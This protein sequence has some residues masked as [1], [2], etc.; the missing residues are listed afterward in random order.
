[1]RP[2]TEE[3]TKLVFAKLACYIGRNIQLLIDRKDEN[4]CF[5][6]LG[7]RVYYVK[8]SIVRAAN[9]IGRDDLLSVGTCFGKF[10]HNGQFR[11][12][13]TCLDYLSQYAKYKVWIKPSSENSFV[14]GNHVLKAGLGRITDNTP[15]NQGV[16]VYTMGDIP[17]G[18]GT[19][20]KSTAD[21][22]HLD[23]SAI[24]VYRQ[25][26]VGEYVRNEDDGLFS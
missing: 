17:L 5:R 25:S 3:E 2:L 24:V 15:V 19:T 4:Y 21:C 20:A 12:Q 11:L 9:C 13:V 10:T 26:D 14:Y 23:P 8:E 1:M 22:R 18:F 6:V 16:I 7:K